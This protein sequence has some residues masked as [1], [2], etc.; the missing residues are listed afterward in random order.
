MIEPQ[1]LNFG[2]VEDGQKFESF[3]ADWGVRCIGKESTHVN[4]NDFVGFFPILF[5]TLRPQSLI[6]GFEV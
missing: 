6:S 5:L 3:A 1:F 4:L 2:K